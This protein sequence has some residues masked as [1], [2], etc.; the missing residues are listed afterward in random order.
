MSPT[1]FS[2][3][4]KQRAMQQQLHHSHN[5]HPATSNLGPVSPARSLSPNPLSNAILNGGSVN[6]TLPNNSM[7]DPYFFSGSNSTSM[8]SNLYPPQQYGRS[9]MFDSNGASSHFPAS[10]YTN[11]FGNVGSSFLEPNNFY[12]MGSAQQQQTGAVGA[13]GGMGSVI[14][15]GALSNGQLQLN[16][17]SLSV[18]SSS[19]SA[20]TAINSPGSSANNPDQ[21][22]NNLLDGMNSFYS[23]QGP[24]QHL[25]V[26]N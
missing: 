13:I 26:A 6:G 19:V 11:G 2:N 7:Q 8:A 1:E 12:G 14:S 25:L 16:G 22:S 3:Y 23:N 9:N 15:H 10:G 17:S 5:G 4:I 18:S 24:Y 20:L 21:T